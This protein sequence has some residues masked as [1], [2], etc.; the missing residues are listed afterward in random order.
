MYRGYLRETMVHSLLG[1]AAIAALLF[2]SL[3][4]PRRVLDVAAACRGSARNIR[5]CWRSPA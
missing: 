1:A 2:E 4:S 3:R 5:A